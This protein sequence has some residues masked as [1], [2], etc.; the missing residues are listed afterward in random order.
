MTLD[1][2]ADCARLRDGT[3]PAHMMGANVCGVWPEDP[4]P[5]PADVD[6]CDGVG[7]GALSNGLLGTGVHCSGTIVFLR[8]VRQ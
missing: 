3:V 6:V 5:P 2:G 1:G 8:Q 7:E 4:D